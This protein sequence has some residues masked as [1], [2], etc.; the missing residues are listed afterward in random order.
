MRTRFFATARAIVAAGVRTRGQIK[1]QFYNTFVGVSGPEAEDYCNGGNL[2]IYTSR[3]FEAPGLWRH[4]FRAKIL[5]T[6]QWAGQAL[7]YQKRRRC[8]VRNL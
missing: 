8:R 7:P 1:N 3:S 5:K 2:K 4:G 6:G